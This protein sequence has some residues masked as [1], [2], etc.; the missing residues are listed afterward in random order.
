VEAGFYKDS[1]SKVAGLAGGGIRYKLPLRLSLGMALFLL[2]TPSINDGRPIM[3]PLPLLSYTR[4]F[5]TVSA[6]YLPKYKSLNRYHSIAG[7]LTFY[8]WR[9]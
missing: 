9:K 6:T 8:F 3:A 2:S 4:N 7:Y 1:F 5:V